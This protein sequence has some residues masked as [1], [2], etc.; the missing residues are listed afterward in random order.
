MKAIKNFFR[1]M[2]SKDNVNTGR[3]IEVDIAK[4]ICII[5][6]IFVHT[7]E[8]F[9]YVEIGNDVAIYAL[10]RIGNTIFGASLFMFC[11]GLGMNYTN[12]NN[13]NN[14]IFRGIKLFIIGLLLNF[15][16]AGLLL[17]IGR[18]MD[19]EWVLVKDI[20][21][22][23]FEVDILFF[24][25]LALILFGL[26]RKIKTPIWAIVIISV[27]VSILGTIFNG[28]DLG[29]E[30]LNCLVGLFIGTTGDIAFNTPACF[31]LCNW[32]II[33][34]AGY[35]FA[36]ALK[37]VNKKAHFYLVFSSIALVVVSLYVALCIGP[38]AGYFQE[39]FRCT[40]HIATYNALISMCGAVLAY[41]LFY[42]VSKVLPKFLLTGATNL[43]RNTL[44]VYC[45]QWLI[46]ANATVLVEG[47]WP[48]VVFE[49]YQLVLAALGVL[50]IAILVAWLFN[51]ILA[52]S[53]KAK[54][55]TNSI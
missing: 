12:K 5:G 34:M 7:F 1:Q 22:Q 25:G 47:Y 33:V 36:F 24:A 35:C 27:V 18:I 9:S 44:V 43:A 40:Y 15:F 31:P 48:D 42:F 28:Y 32:F 21:Y 46:I 30:F 19:P 23:I 11:M 3:Q 8:N 37:K 49:Q 41:G 26:L 55:E 38:K 52:K 14:Y 17:I 6:M 50:A 20:I 13:P 51:I 29:N 16:R 10:L 53:R 4:A 54:K 45:V 2:F 39:E